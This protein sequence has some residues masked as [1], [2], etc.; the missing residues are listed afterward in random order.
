M[1][2]TLC[3][4]ASLTAGA[5]A[6]P[7]ALWAAPAHL[8]D[9]QYLAAVRCQALIASPAL[10]KSDTAAVNAML[11]SETVGRPSELQD[12]ADGIRDAAALQARHAGPSEKAELIA[13]RDGACR[14]Y[15][16]SGTTTAAAQFAQPTA[17]N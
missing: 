13:E 16:A 3:L 14:A 4:V 9:S 10:G 1:F 8:T 12:R 5:A 7:G 6:A 2:K 11:K 15:G 17:A